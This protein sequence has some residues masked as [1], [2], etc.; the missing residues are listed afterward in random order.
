MTVTPGPVPVPVPWFVFSQMLKG[1]R[2]II[3]LYSFAQGTHT[4]CRADRPSV[5]VFCLLNSV[6]QYAIISQRTIVDHSIHAVAEAPS[7]SQ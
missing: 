7:I 1:R 6:C 2:L 3:A 4:D 5:L